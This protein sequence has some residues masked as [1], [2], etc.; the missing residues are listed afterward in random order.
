MPGVV[1]LD[2]MAVRRSAEAKLH[3]ARAAAAE[4]LERIEAVR[5]RELEKIEVATAWGQLHEQGLSGV[6][7]HG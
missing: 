7:G 4:G 1:G 2:V 5:L 6:I 3:A